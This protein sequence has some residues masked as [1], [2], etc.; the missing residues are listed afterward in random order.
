VANNDNHPTVESSGSSAKNAKRPT[1]RTSK[2][3][4][5]QQ[6]LDILQ[7]AVLKCEQSGID[8]KITPFWQHGQKSVVIVLANVTLEDSQLLLLADAGK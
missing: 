5:A 8:A 6:A 2:P 7:E 3:I 4:P 1:S